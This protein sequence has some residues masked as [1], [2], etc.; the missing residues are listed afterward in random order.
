MA[1]F[2]GDKSGDDSADQIGIGKREVELAAG[3]DGF[4]NDDGRQYGDRHMA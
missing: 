3:S 4:R 2:P 1:C